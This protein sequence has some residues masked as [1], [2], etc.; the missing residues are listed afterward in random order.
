MTFPAMRKNE[1]IPREDRCVCI[2]A[3]HSIIVLCHCHI[4]VAR[5]DQGKD[6]S[7]KRPIASNAS[8]SRSTQLEPKS[9]PRNEQRNEWSELGKRE[10]LFG[11][12]DSLLPFSRVVPEVVQQQQ[13]AELRVKPVKMLLP[14]RDR[15]EILYELVFETHTTESIHESTM[16]RVGD[17]YGTRG[18][19]KAERH[20]KQE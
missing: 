16:R 9:Q 2:H 13:F 18:R 12:P 19:Q 14:F 3:L 11:S 20:W 5:R 6:T 17:F 4:E 15:V 8:P 1:Q 7:E 10:Q